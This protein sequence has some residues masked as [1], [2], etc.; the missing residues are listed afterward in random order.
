MARVSSLALSDHRSK[1]F[2]AGKFLSDDGSIDSSPPYFFKR[3][4]PA[5]MI[6]QKQEMTN[7]KAL[8]N[9]VWI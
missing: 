1:L 3:R 6:Q 4:F 2:P 5:V 9:N 8:N 7:S